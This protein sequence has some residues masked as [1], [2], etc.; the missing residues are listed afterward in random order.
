MATFLSNDVLFSTMFFVIF[1]LVILTYSYAQTNRT[2]NTNKTVSFNIGDPAGNYTIKLRQPANS[3]IVQLQFFSNTKFFSA[4]GAKTTYTLGST[5]GA[6][7]LVASGDLTISSGT[8]SFPPGA[9][10]VATILSTLSA[11]VVT[12]KARDVFLTISPGGAVDS[13]GSFKVTMVSQ[14]I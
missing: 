13:N 9:A 6:S 1:I 3:V 2:I 14:K 4:T 11:P 10:I 5:Q 8:Y 7:D 12:D